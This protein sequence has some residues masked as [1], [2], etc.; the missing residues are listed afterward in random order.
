[1]GARSY[2]YD[3]NGNVLSDG[4]R[5]LTWTAQNMV[6][7]LQRDGQAWSLLY[8]ADGTRVVRE[9]A[10][11]NSATYNIN[12]TYE[13]R[14]DGAELSEARISVLGA[15]GRVVAEV[16]AERTA[17]EENSLWENR[18]KFVHDD[19]L[20]SAHMITDRDGTVEARVMYG[21]WGQARDGNNWYLPATETE[22]EDL[23]IGF[24]GHQPELDAGLVNMR[25]RMYDPV[26]GR[27]LSVD[28][29]IE[30]ALEVGTWNAYSYVLNRP[31]SLVDPTGLAAANSVDDDR[32]SEA[33]AVELADLQLDILVADF[34]A[35]VGGIQAVNFDIPL[36]VKQED[37]VK[38]D[39]RRSAEGKP[40]QAVVIEP[41]VAGAT[42]QATGTTKKPQVTESVYTDPATAALYAAEAVREATTYKGHTSDAG[43]EWGTEVFEF[44]VPI[45]GAGRPCVALTLYSFS[46]PY[47]GRDPTEAERR[48]DI[49]AIW[50]PR[51]ERSLPAGARVLY[52][53]H[54]HPNNTPPDSFDT[55]RTQGGPPWGGISM[56]VVARD[57]QWIIS[58][59]PLSTSKQYR[60]IDRIQRF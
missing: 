45:C 16:F 8:D 18:K 14:F 24:T 2:T 54:S 7:S 37:R 44:T 22:L 4:E 35:A 60:E 59:I 48:M 49:V 52:L 1:M 25:G 20:G 47:K 32:R 43:G 42:K 15:T 10:A 34:L 57:R 30:N 12:S 40:V 55:R 41:K 19:H 13:L 33:T 5:T 39:V 50:E 36:S 51:S 56:I 23:P 21:P 26:I 28:P 17:L 31:L 3:D 29:V 6:R 46:A 58:T 27:F 9:E 38:E 53:V 11:S